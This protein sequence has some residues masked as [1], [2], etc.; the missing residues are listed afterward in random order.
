MKKYY[1]K[2]LCFVLPIGLLAQN[3]VQD[4]IMIGLSIPEII[5]AEDKEESERLLSPNRIEK[6]DAINIFQDAP[7]SSADILQKSGAV[8]VQMSQSG[9]GSPIIRGFEA[10][11]VLLVVDGVRLNNAIY[12]SGHLQNSISISPLML[13]NVDIIFGPSSVKYGSD[14]LGG[15]VHYHTQSPQSGQAWKANLLQRYSTINNGINLYYD[16]SWSKGK[17]SFLQ[18]INLNRFGNLKMGEQRYHGYTD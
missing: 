13:E 5:F 17:W 7:T 18:G 11:R 14:A 6:I 2:L 4:T 15:V 3:A 16:H 9:G 1:L 10:N 8:A 12:R